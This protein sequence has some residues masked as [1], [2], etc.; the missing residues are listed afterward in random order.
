MY[1]TQTQSL[2][3]FQIHMINPLSC[4]CAQFQIITLYVRNTEYQTM[5]QFS[6]NYTKLQKSF[7]SLLWSDFTI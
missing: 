3:Y 1:S 2:R 7:L 4:N 6:Q 5:I